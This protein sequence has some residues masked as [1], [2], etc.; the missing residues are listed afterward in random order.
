M[1][2]ITTHNTTDNASLQ[3]KIPRPLADR[4]VRTK[5]SADD[6]AKVWSWLRSGQ[7]VSTAFDESTLFRALHSSAYHALQP[8][9]RRPAVR[10]EREEWTTRWDRIRGHLVERN[11]GLVYSAI[12]RFGFKS[13]D[14]DEQRSVALFTLLK[15]VDRFDPWRGFRFSTYATQSIRRALIQLARTEKRQRPEMPL[16]LSDQPESLPRVDAWLEWHTDGLRR[17]LREN[18]GQLSTK[19][20]LVISRRFPMDG[21][22]Q[23]TLDQIGNVMGLS[24]E[25]VRQIQN[26]ALK[27]LREVLEADVLLQ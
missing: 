22:R 17:A 25:G 12:D 19:E 9:G 10:A 7:K 3:L 26:R 23:H 13:V 21:S 1:V 5:E 2:A 14:W 20:S 27:K 4:R 11:L 18:Q 6:A 8:V 16:D 15:A 24:N